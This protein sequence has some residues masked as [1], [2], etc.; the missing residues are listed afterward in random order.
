MASTSPT[1]FQERFQEVLDAAREE[2]VTNGQLAAQIGCSKNMVAH[3]KAGR[4]KPQR[5]HAEP[6][7]RLLGISA[8]ELFERPSETKRAP[9]PTDPDDLLSRL[10]AFELD[11][12]L[13]KMQ[14]VA[15]R[16]QQLH[17]SIPSLLDLLSEAKLYVEKGT[18]K[19]HGLHLDASPPAPRRRHRGR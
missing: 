5:R 19:S 2:G 4:H 14:E 7:S 17:G 3:W 10:T 11:I 18:T 8:D 9:E 16:F 1:P 6:I 15:P 12:V 13:E